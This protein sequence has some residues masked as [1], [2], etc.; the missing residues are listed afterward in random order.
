MK[1]A[2]KTKNTNKK[3]VKRKQ[4]IVPVKQV[5]HKSVIWRHLRL[6]EHKHTGKVLS[7]HHTSHLALMFML[8]VAGFIIYLSQQIAWAA[9]Q[10]SAGSVSVGVVVPGVPPTI[11]AAITYPLTGAT[12]KDVSEVT[13]TGTCQPNSFVV[14]LDNNSLD[15]STSCTSAG[16][17]SLSVQLVSGKNVLTA[18]NYD[19]I[20]QAGPATDAVTVVLELT[21]P[22]IDVSAPVLPDNPSII[23]GLTNNT[24]SDQSSVGIGVN[25]NA[26]NC[27]NYTVPSNLTTGGEPHA[28]VVCIPRIFDPNVSQKMGLLVWGGQPPYALRMDWGDS[29][30]ATLASLS[31]PGYKTIKFQYTSAGVYNIKVNLID[32]KDKTGVASTSVQV[33]GV[34]QTPPTAPQIV[35]NALGSSWLD[36]PVP[37]YLTSVVTTLGF[38]GGDIFNRILSARNKSFGKHRAAH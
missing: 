14:V 12:L 38:W 5:G 29:N 2:P 8:V 37:L 36:T 4:Q 21:V 32:A 24:F 19:N 1:T 28:M 34:S 11:G 7:H 16:V 27:D 10:I 33:N 9:Q 15:G 35:S 20:N 23:S 30:N 6:V 25:S 17:F 3:V 18:K 13:V 31:A 26:S 22:V